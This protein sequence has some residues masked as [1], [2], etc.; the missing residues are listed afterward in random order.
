VPAVLDANYVRYTLK[1][2]VGDVLT[3]RSESGGAESTVSLRIAGLLAPSI[4][5]GSAVIAESA[6]EKLFPGTGGYRFLLVDVP[7]AAAEKTGQLLSRL[8]EN[9]GLALT[10]ATDRL[11]EFNAVQNTY[12]RIFS[13]L[14]GLGLMLSTAGLGLLLARTVLERRGEFGLL[15]AVGFQRGA[16]RRIIL[17]ENVFLLLAGMAVGVVA[18]V[19][20]VW[21]VSQGASLP[22][23]TLAAI[24]VGGVVFCGLA[25]H[26]AL[27]G[28][29]INALRSE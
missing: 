24:L 18:A 29:L 9:R 8:L 1:L 4:W 25:A 7:P 14:G 6:F 17:G 11:N 13:A 27:R 19:L 10:P 21:P 3:V 22:L 12:L 23:G 15:Q 5:Q 26:F 28:R 16:L 20:A 2:A